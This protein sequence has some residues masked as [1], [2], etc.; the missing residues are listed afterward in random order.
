MNDQC[1]IRVATSNLE[2]RI[3]FYKKSLFGVIYILVNLDQ[4]VSLRRWNLTIVFTEVTVYI[5]DGVSN[6]AWGQFLS[7]WL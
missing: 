3:A 7:S 5:N 6:N 4:Y 2:V 1:I